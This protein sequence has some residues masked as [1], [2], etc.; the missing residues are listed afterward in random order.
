MTPVLEA[1][2]EHLHYK[3][4]AYDHGGSVDE[5]SRS[6]VDAAMGGKTHTVI[7][8]LS[9]SHDVDPDV[10]EHLEKHGYAIHDYKSGLA[11]SQKTT[12][13]PERGIPL[14][15]KTVKESIGKVLQKTN[16]PDFIKNAYA[17]DPART[18]AKSS[19]LHIL[20][21]HHPFATIGKT[22]GTNWETESCMNAE[23]G[24]IAII[25]RMIRS[26]SRMKHF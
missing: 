10:E 19:G 12:G 17:N 24:A 5:A 15:T 13:A 11:S 1:A 6:K 8:M 20:I 3:A 16:A 4:D 21:S 7:P 26:I 25:L 9:A 22:S 2:P 23:S 18:G 14:S